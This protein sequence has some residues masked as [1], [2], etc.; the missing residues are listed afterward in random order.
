LCRLLT[1]GRTLQHTAVKAAQNQGV[2]LI[3][4]FVGN[5]CEFRDG[6]ID[7]R[8]EVDLLEAKGIAESLGMAYFE[9]S[10]VSPVGV[11]GVVAACGCHLWQETERSVS[12][13]FTNAAN[14]SL[15][16]VTGEQH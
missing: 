5:K 8:A 9:T 1:H 7:S 14:R 10:A 15:L 16:V 11:F 6:S 2:N 4:A 3:G 13:H 12:V